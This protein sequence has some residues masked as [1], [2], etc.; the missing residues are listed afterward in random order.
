MPEPGNILVVQTAFLG[1]VILTLPMVQI[2]KRHFPLSAIDVLVVPRAAELLANHPAV[3]EAVVFDKRGKDAGVR[4]L[5]RMA[6]GLRKR[7]YRIAF[8]PHRSLRSA[9]VVLA[10]GIPQRIGFHSSAGRLF[11][12]RIVRYDSSIHEIDRNIHL[13]RAVDIE[14]KE[15]EFPDLYPSGDD[16][17][18]VESFLSANNG[19][20]MRQLIGIAPGTVWNTKQWLKERFIELAGRLISSGFTP[21]LVGGNEDAVLCQSIAQSVSIGNIIVAAGGLTLLQSAE[22]IR[23]CRVLVTNDSAPM[24]LA[25]AMRTPVVAV[26]G[27]TVPEFGFAPYGQYDVVVETN[28]LS[29]R[30]CSIHGGDECPITTFDCMVDISSETVHDSVL[31]VLKQSHAVT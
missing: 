17:R 12:S 6:S 21:V 5:A 24:H 19:G 26:F 16:K 18:K 15:K 20:N 11:L 4:G 3:H 9:V 28:G 2:L 23:R 1:D 25:V 10:A 13:L 29:C 31:Q 7:R 8:V 27:A 30:P 14:T 22:L